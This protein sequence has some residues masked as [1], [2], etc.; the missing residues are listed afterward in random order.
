M[1]QLQKNLKII[2]IVIITLASF[3]F[4]FPQRVYSATLLG[5]SDYIPDDS[6]GETLVTHNV[7]FVIPLNG[8]NIV[9]TDYIRIILT[10]FTNVTAPTSGSG[11]SG[12]PTYGAFSN[13]AYVTGVNASSGGGIGISGVTAT[14]PANPSDFGVTVQIANDINGTIV[15][16]STTTVAQVISGTPTVS[17]TVAA[18]T[19]S[20]EFFGYTSPNAF[21]TI[22]LNGGV[23]GTTVATIGGNFYKKITGLL[24]GH[25]YQ[26]SIFAQD[27]ELRTSQTVSFVVMT[28]PN[29]NIIINNIVIPSTI[30]LA[31]TLISQGDLLGIFGLSHPYSQISVFVEG[32]SHV[33]LADQNGSWFYN[34]NSKLEP[35]GVGS[36]IAYAKEV[37]VGGYESIYTRIVSFIVSYCGIADLNCDGFVNLTDFSIMLFYWHLHKPANP[38][39]DVSG[40]NYVDLTDFS[41]MLYYWTG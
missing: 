16:D 13:V 29:S 39:A 21:V 31:K 2:I 23:A 12:T 35:L 36:H 1:P 9:P 11:W 3:S 25:N 10:N 18:Y 26:V 7:G 28:I 40:D 38:R 17:V 32:Y 22:L 6:P 8:H 33:V 4:L 37:A 15:Y 27:S 19:S 30:T 5:A 24:A 14:N 34:F 41:I 20:I